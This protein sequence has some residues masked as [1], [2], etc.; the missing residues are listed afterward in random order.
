MHHVTSSEFLRHTSCRSFDPKDDGL[1]ELADAETVCR[2]IGIDCFFSEAKGACP[3]VIVHGLSHAVSD[4]H[5]LV[6]EITVSLVMD[7]ACLHPIIDNFYLR[8]DIDEI[9]HTKRY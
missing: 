7:E 4:R 3:E 2:S 6:A 8:S 9:F 5:A 1:I